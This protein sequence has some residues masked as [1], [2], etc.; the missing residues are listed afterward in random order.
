MHVHVHSPVALCRL[1]PPPPFFLSI[2][3]FLLSL[4]YILSPLST[5]QFPLT[6]TVSPTTPPSQSTTLPT[7][8]G[9]SVSTLPVGAVVGIAVGGAVLLILV[10]VVVIILLYVC[11]RLSSGKQGFYKTEESNGK[12]ASM[13]HYSASLRQISSEQVTVPET[14]GVSPMHS[15]GLRPKEFYL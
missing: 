1:C 9:S 7:G 2:S 13:V 12:V 4:S 11:V 3:L 15:D 6:T 10:I 14:N 8:T 5:D